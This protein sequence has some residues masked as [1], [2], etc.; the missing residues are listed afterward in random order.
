MGDDV[1]HGQWVGEKH[2]H[3]GVQAEASPRVVILPR[4]WGEWVTR[5][6]SGSGSQ[7]CP[8]SIPS[9]QPF[10]LLALQPCLLA[11]EGP[12]QL[13]KEAP[14]WIWGHR[15]HEGRPIPLEK[16]IGIS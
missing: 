6:L 16:L 1:V 14:G 11:P 9:S 13:T 5:G 4:A 3:G 8:N 2:S 10:R 7:P 15:R 12:L